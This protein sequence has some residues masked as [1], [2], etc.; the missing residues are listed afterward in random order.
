MFRLVDWGVQPYSAEVLGLHDS[1]WL[2]T[3]PYSGSA[4]G[5][6]ILYNPDRQEVGD[7][8]NSVFDVEDSRSGTISYLSGIPERN[9]PTCHKYCWSP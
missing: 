4:T 9:I 8:D 6:S 2:P 3:H 7:A 5:A 1:C